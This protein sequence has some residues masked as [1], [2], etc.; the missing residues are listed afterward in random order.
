VAK[1]LQAKGIL[2][3]KKEMA[4]GSPTWHYKLDTKAF[5][6]KFREFLEGV[7]GS[8]EKSEMSFSAGVDAAN[9]T[10]LESDIETPYTAIAVRD[11]SGIEANLRML[12][13]NI[14]PTKKEE[15]ALRR[16]C[17]FVEKGTYT[18]DDIAGCAKWILKTFDMITVKPTSIED[19]LPTYLA[20][21]G[22][23]V[24]DQPR[25]E[26]NAQRADRINKNRDYDAISKNAAKRI[27]AEQMEKKARQEA[28]KELIAK[29]KEEQW[30]EERQEFKRK[31]ERQEAE[32][33]A[34]V[35]YEA[36]G[37]RITKGKPLQWL[38]GEMTFNFICGIGKGMSEAEKKKEQQA[39]SILL[40]QIATGNMAEDKYL[41]KAVRMRNKGMNITAVDLLTR[42]V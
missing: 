20:K 36:G 26:S 38:E 39:H 8:K 41:D 22:S 28:E 24:L 30:E 35:S 31:K 13:K 33:D 11:T 10:Q 14:P 42:Q 9:N 37:W 19:K 12:I 32:S 18:P 6:E 16:L 40:H 29:R 3:M 34:T 23:G 7:V 15:D 21:K 1:T 27:W 4:Y 17:G 5:E 25:Y 2:K